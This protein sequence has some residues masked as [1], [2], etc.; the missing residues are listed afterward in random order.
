ML[1]FLSIDHSR[2]KGR[3]DQHRDCISLAFMG[4]KQEQR[5]FEG[6]YTFLMPQRKRV[7]AGFAGQIFF[8]GIFG[9]LLYKKTCLISYMFP[10]YFVHGVLVS[11]QC[12]AGWKSVFRCQSECCAAI[13]WMSPPIRQGW[14]LHVCVP[15]LSA[16]QT[17]QAERLAMDFS[18]C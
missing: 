16:F 7:P 6:T 12:S 14:A 15:F 4:Y 5:R 11:H 3:K 17:Q 9:C 1:L 10:I 8:L 13:L 2:V 18:A